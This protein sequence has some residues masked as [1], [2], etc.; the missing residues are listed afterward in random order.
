MDKLYDT[1][2]TYIGGGCF[3]FK[4]IKTSDTTESNSKSEGT[5]G[6][7]IKP[8]FF[9]KLDKIENDLEKKLA[10]VVQ[11]KLDGCRRENEVAQDLEKQYPEKDGYQI[12]RERVLCDKDG[13]PVIDEQTGQKRRVDF[14]VIKDGKVAD[15]VEVTSKTA[16]KRDQLAKE[17]RIRDNGGNYI[18]D[19]NGNICRIPSNVETK[20]ER[21]E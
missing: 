7:D 3:M 6:K 21:R 13:N 11:N 9:D 15:M 14:V 10:N 19:Y 8:S 18:K 20:V 5:S 17:Y 2:R 4:E 16:P 1:S 12:L